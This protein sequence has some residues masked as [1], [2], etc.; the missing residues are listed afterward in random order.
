MGQSISR[1]ESFVKEIKRSLRE[2]GVRVKKK[3]LVSFFCFVDE[4]CPWFILSGPD[5]HPLSWQKVGK[6]LNRLLEKEG[7]NAVPVSCFSYWGLIRD[8]IEGAETDSN[9]R[10][11]LSVA[12]ETLKQLS[13][14]PSVK[15]G[16]TSSPC[17]SVVVDVEPSPP[18]GDSLPQIYPI[19][20]KPGPE[21]LDPGDATVLEDEAAKY[22]E[23]VWPSSHT[24]F[25]AGRPAT[26]PPPYNPLHIPQAV[27]D[28]FL[29]TKKQ[30]QQQIQSLKSVFTLQ[31]ELAN[32]QLEVS[33]LR[34]SIFS[35]PQSKPPKGPR[36]KPFVSSIMTRS[37]TRP[38]QDLDTT[39]EASTDA[40]EA[41]RASTPD[42]PAYDDVAQSEEEGKDPHNDSENEGDYQNLLPTVKRI[43]FKT[44]KD[45]HSAIKSYGLTAP[46]TLSILE[47][48]PGDG[49]LLPGEWTRVAQSVL[50]RGEFLTWKA[51]FLDRGETQAMRNQKNPRS[52]MATW[53]AD[54]ICGRGDFASERKQRSLSAGILSQTAAAA[55][56][57]WRAIP[58]KGSVTMPLSKIVQGPHE[59]FSQFVARLQETAERVLGP[60]DGEGKLVKQLAYENA[61]AACKAALKG[62][63]RNLD[64]HGM[65]RL[66]NDVD[67]TAHQIKLAIGAIMQHANSN[68]P[69]PQNTPV[70]ARCCFRCGQPGHVARLCS[71]PHTGQ[72]LAPP[73]LAP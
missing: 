40:Q 24:F 7:P 20:P 56:G 3:D 42:D 38:S 43:K 21:P 53:T 12:T 59:P 65:I 69:V 57:A 29:E 58:P 22:H 52:P 2:R 11:L 5:I 1:E 71:L 45:L 39:Q 10:Q 6:D 13:R 50:S 67:S 14:P 19:I 26:R 48:L 33:A 73:L 66:C 49:F 23:P 34:N 70:A 17:P 64:I 32:L 4:K 63:L 46:F 60:E 54:K 18:F 44:V 72:I 30:L 61:N 27:L 16:A 35:G 28:P 51:E 62:H 47:S 55:I 37:G 31:S 68:T 9:K 8:I 25:A 36:A 15:G 41:P